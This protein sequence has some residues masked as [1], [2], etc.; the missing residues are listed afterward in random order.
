[1]AASNSESLDSLDDS[2]VVFS[3]VP[4]RRRFVLRRGAEL[5]SSSERVFC[6][7]SKPRSVRGSCSARGSGCCAA[8]CDCNS[9]VAVAVSIKRSVA[10]ANAA[11]SP[12]IR[13]SGRVAAV[14]D[15]G[16]SADGVVGRCVDVAVGV[17]GKIV[18]GWIAGC[19]FGGDI[20]CVF[21][22]LGMN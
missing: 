2:I 19:G 10:E 8:C 22:P 17:G 4:V 13:L 1:M 16:V 20:T 14:A 11:L 6:S 12:G 15:G 18:N 5:F 3:T 21:A 7:A 9:P